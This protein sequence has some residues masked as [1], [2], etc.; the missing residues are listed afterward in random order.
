MESPYVVVRDATPVDLFKILMDAIFPNVDVKTLAN[1][2]ILQVAEDKLLG[3]ILG[4]IVFD[5]GE[6]K[7]TGYG[8]ITSLFINRIF[9]R[10]GHATRLVTNAEMD[11]DKVSRCCLRLS[12]R[13]DDRHRSITLLQKDGV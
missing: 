4:F 9:Q 3:V 13:P 11:L 10:K 8:H 1:G 2:K 12:V 5:N 7:R 6:L